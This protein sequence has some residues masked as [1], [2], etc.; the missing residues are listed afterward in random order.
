MD[1]QIR[2]GLLSTARINRRIIPAIRASAR[3][4]LAAVASRNESTAIAYAK[5]WDIPIMFGSYEAMLASDAVDVV[6][7]SLP[8]HLHAEWAIRAM[9]AGKHVLC[10][11]PFALTVPEVDRMIQASLSTGCVL[12]EAFMYRHHP[13]TKSVLEWVNEGRLGKV[14]NVFGVFSFKHPGGDEYRLNPLQGG[15]SLWDV[16]V[17]PISFAQAVFGIA[18]MRVFGVSRLGPTGVDLNFTGLLEYDDG[19]SAQILASFDQPFNMRVEIFGDQGRIDIPRPFTGMESTGYFLF[20]K[21]ENGPERVEYP[22]KELYLGEVEDM[23]SA[24]LDGKA[25]EVSLIQSRDHIRTVEA[26]L[27]SAESGKPVD[28]AG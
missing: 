27:L 22:P 16:G 17:Y 2:W 20:D 4:R 19:R 7:I 5:E 10:E 23:E 15:G 18:P 9:H 8:N 14:L 21:G 1:K 6:Y 3:S 11:K 26:L 25:A 24:V 28:L 13:Q 12:T